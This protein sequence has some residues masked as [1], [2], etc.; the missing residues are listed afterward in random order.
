MSK[1]HDGAGN[2]RS[3]KTTFNPP[4][5]N[6]WSFSPQ[7]VK[8]KGSGKITLTR[9][10]TVSPPW[11]F[12]D[13]VLPGGLRGKVRKDGEEYVI[14]DDGEPTDGK[15]IPYSV[16]VSWN[17]QTFISPITSDPIAAPAA[18]VAFAAAAV[19]AGALD[20]AER[21]PMVMNE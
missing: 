6:S 5:A 2:A 13:S 11:K 15:Y 14:D 18:T 21:P 19:V 9:D 8:M 10:T 20:A 16:T 17:G 4:D 12:V 7:K 3:V 1:E